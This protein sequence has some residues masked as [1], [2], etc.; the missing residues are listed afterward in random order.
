MGVEWDKAALVGSWG[1]CSVDSIHFDLIG[2]YLVWPFAS[3]FIK[4][5]LLAHSTP[6]FEPQRLLCWFAR[7]AKLAMLPANQQG[8]ASNLDVAC[9]EGAAE[10]ANIGHD[11]HRSVHTCCPSTCT[12]SGPCPYHIF[13]VTS[14]IYP[15]SAVVLAAYLPAAVPARLPYCQASPGCSPLKLQHTSHS[16]AMS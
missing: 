14:A 13:L 10:C 12:Q 4:G 2:T 1:A 9:L 11:L 15:S 6:K 7:Q 3:R 16:T 5:Q 8:V